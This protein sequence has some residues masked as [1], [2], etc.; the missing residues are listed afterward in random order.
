MLNCPRNGVC[1]NC[2]YVRSMA[3]GK[4]QRDRVFSCSKFSGMPLTRLG[5]D[6]RYGNRLLPVEPLTGTCFE[7]EKT[8]VLTGGWY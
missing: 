7:T 5:Y 4:N 6:G 2:K 8:N 1:A 3:V